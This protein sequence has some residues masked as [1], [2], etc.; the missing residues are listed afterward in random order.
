MGFNDFIK[1]SVLE[2][3]A[4]NQA[5]TAGTVIQILMGLLVSVSLGLLIYW[6]YTK[7]FHGVVYSRMYCLTLTG[8]SVLSCMVT[9]AISTNIVISLGM[10]GALSII[11]YRTAIKDPL[12]LLYM[13]WAVTVGITSGAGMYLLALIASSVM[14]LLIFG[15]NRRD[16][17]GRVYLMVVHYTNDKCGDLIQ[18]QLSRFKYHVKSKTL[19]GDQTEYSAEVYVKDND[20]HFL[21]IIRDIEGVKDVTLMQYN[22]EY[23]G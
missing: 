18:K 4:F 9:L 7:F 17:K 3:G 15:V 6:V 20:S 22:G 8:M 11:R 13:F 21:E 19:R 14:I 5:I 10:V 1:K 23:H 12:D 16:L 2:A